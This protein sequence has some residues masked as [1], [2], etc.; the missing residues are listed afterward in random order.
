MGSKQ[1]ISILMCSIQPL[2]IVTMKHFTPTP[3]AAL[4]RVLRL[5]TTLG[6]RRANKRCWN[7]MSALATV[8]HNEVSGLLVGMP[9]V[10]DRSYASE[11]DVLFRDIC[12]P[13][14][15]LES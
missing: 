7:R 13:C 1:T 8:V 6:T 14:S 10:P 9:P 3:F 4:K 5:A 11:L 15:L 2:R 12:C